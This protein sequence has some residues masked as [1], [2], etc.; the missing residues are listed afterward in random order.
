MKR[1]LG[2]IVLLGFLTSFMQKDG[3]EVHPSLYQESFSP[4]ER[5]EYRLNFS[6]FT[7][8]RARTIVQ[9]EIYSING[10]PSYKMDAYGNTSGLIDWLA[11]VE[12]HWGAYMDTASL[13][14]HKTYRNIIEGRYRK[15]EIVNFDYKLNQ[16]EVKELDQET[17]VYK[18]PLFY[19]SPDQYVYDMLGGLMLLRSLDFDTI[20][21]G[22]TIKVKAFFEDTFY[23][24]KSVL[25]GREVVKTKA[26]KFRALVLAPMMPKNSIIEEGDDS[27]RLWISDDENKIPLLA[28]VQMFIGSA[29]IELTSFRGLRNPVSSYV[30]SWW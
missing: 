12:D 25:I 18:E 19:E 1:W 3:E 13:L 16:I 23:D 4:G 8:G 14:P 2:Y 17:K 22:D 9:E 7:V 28:K 21:V 6:I 24:F 30:Q 11:H 27:I 29:G 20:Q 10:R 26:G 15:N 5:L